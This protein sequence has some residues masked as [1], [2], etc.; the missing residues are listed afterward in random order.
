MKNWITT[1]FG[2]LAATG[3]GLAHYT[4]G[5]LASIGTLVSI[6]CTALLGSYAQDAK[7]TNN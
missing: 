5:T 1:V 3:A 2:V 6:A 7:S 4:T